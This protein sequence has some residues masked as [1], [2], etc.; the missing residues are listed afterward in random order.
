M[1][2]MVLSQPF[3]VIYLMNTLSVISGFF[4]VNNFKV[5]GIINGLNDENY[6]SVL[7]SVGA[8]FNS[9]RFVWSLG[10]DHFSYK[11]VYGILL[12]M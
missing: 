3:I 9:I 8:V 4:A 10:T 5:Y 7:G 11:T 6:L 12:V 1:I 2:R